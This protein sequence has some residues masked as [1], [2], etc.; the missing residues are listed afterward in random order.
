[1]VGKRRSGPHQPLSPVY[2][3]LA[4]ECAIDFYQGVKTDLTDA[5]HCF[6]R[7]EDSARSAASEFKCFLGARY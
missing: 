1:M 7:R 4:S 5:Y 3:P 2:P 6:E